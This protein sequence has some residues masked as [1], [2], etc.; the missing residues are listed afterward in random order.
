[1]IKG[2]KIATRN[3]L[4]IY[5][6]DANGYSVFTPDGKCLGKGYFYIGNAER[7]C[8][9]N[10]DY[11]KKPR[12]YKKKSSDKIEES[13]DSTLSTLDKVKEI[14]NKWKQTDDSAYDCMMEIANLVEEDN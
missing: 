1:M 10:T 7:L 8:L 3:N 11:V 6:S 5:Y 2:R 14:V 9:N 4:S 12:N 13:S